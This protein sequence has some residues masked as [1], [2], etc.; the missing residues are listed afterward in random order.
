MDISNRT[1]EQ[2]KDFQNPSLYLSQNLN[3]K[4]SKNI[5]GGGKKSKIVF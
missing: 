1:S 2:I 5:G 4:L 3:D